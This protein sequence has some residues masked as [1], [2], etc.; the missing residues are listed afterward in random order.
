MGS[1]ITKDKRI[2]KNNIRE[3]INKDLEN[4]E[5]DKKI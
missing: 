3:T 2:P 1:Q 5:F 4:N